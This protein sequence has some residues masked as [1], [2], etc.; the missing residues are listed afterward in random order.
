MSVY[1]HV[2]DPCLLRIII[3]AQEDRRCRTG[4]ARRHAPAGGLFHRHRLFLW[5]FWFW[6]GPSITTTT[7]GSRGGHLLGVVVPHLA[8]KGPDP[9]P[10]RHQGALPAGALQERADPGVALLRHHVAVVPASGTLGRL[11]VRHDLM[12]RTRHLD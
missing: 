8:L 5:W 3:Q 1:G 10:L 11:V 7:G 2:G 12:F 9:R 6:F 4:P